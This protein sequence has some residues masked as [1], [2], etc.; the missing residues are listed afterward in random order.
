M[1]QKP[2]ENE[3][4]IVHSF[5]SGDWR[6]LRDIALSNAASDFAYC[7]EQWPTDEESIKGMADYLA[8][9]DSMSAIYAKDID[10]VVCFVNFNRITDEKYL[11]IGHVM[12]LE[13]AGRGYEY[14]GLRLLYKFAFET[15]EIDG[16]RSYW[17]FDD[18]V[19]LEPLMKLGMKVTRKFQNNYFGGKKGTFTGCELKVSREEF[20][21]G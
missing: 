8:T 16:I 11:D 14:E 2:L 13:F 3:H 1:K 5:T 7:D 9:N 17:A 19:K 10:K 12:N 15:M 21:K 18:K 4:V 20:Y 6:D